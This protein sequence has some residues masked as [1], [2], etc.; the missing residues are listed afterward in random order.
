LSHIQ[1]PSP[2]SSSRVHLLMVYV[3]ASVFRSQGSES[4]P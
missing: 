4:D 2:S 3:P 1:N